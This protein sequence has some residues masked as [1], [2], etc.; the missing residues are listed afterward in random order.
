MS[1]DPVSVQNVECRSRVINWKVQQILNEECVSRLRSRDIRDPCASSSS[2]RRTWQR[3][4]LGWVCTMHG[5]PAHHRLQLC[6]AMHRLLL[7]LHNNNNNRF[8]A[9]RTRRSGAGYARRSTLSLTLRSTL[10][11]SV[12]SSKM[13]FARA[14]LD[15]NRARTTTRPASNFSPF[16]FFTLFPFSL[17][18]WHTNRVFFFEK[19]AGKLMECT[20]RCTRECLLLVDFLWSNW[21][22]SSALFHY[23]LGSCKA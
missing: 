21:F 15:E 9:R 20:A 18:Y 1:V 14:R 22:V 5:E 11:L 2:A 7:A 23:I 13:L 17:F 3:N 16:F 19:F 8:L 10:C 4:G 12:F 6:V